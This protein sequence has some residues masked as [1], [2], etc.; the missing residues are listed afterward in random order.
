SVDVADLISER[1]HEYRAELGLRWFGALSDNWSCYYSATQ[2]SGD[3]AFRK[4]A[5]GGRVIRGPAG[6]TFKIRAD[7]A[8]PLRLLVRTGAPIDFPAAPLGWPARVLVLER[9]DTHTPLG[10]ITLPEPGAGFAES[11]VQ[12]EADR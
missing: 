5:D 6:E 4:I 2:V 1:E 10:Q 7:P 12:L 3:G 11:F 9:A 8:R